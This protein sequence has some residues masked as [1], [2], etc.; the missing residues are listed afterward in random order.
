MMQKFIHP[1]KTEED[2]Q[3]NNKDY[4]IHRPILLLPI[5]PILLLFVLDLLICVLHEDL[6]QYLWHMAIL[7]ASFPILLAWEYRVPAQCF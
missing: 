5:Y 1:H 7:S 6:Q 3:E 4:Q 2:E